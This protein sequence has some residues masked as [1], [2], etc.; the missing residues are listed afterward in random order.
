MKS[1]TF[2]PT[3]R[4]RCNISSKGAMLPGRNDAEIGPVNSL[5]ASAEY[6]EYNERYNLRLIGKQICESSNTLP[7]VELDQKSPDIRITKSKY[8]YRLLHNRSTCMLTN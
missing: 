1:R 2:L 6:S 3:V 7:A 5:N 4:H 8:S